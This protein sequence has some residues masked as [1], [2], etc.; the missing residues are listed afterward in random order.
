MTGA[1]SSGKLAGNL[2]QA[3]RGHGMKLSV[4]DG[5]LRLRSAFKLMF[6]AFTFGTGVFFVFMTLLFGLVIALGG[7]IE[8]DSGPVQ[9]AEAAATL[10]PMLIL[11]PITIAIYA[12]FLAAIGAL[13]LLIYRLFWPIRIDG[14]I[15]PSVFE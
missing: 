15:A 6:F 7:P 4:K 2:T 10:A 12:G 8:T 1:V 5:K 13:G 3:G 14:A 9:G 11:M